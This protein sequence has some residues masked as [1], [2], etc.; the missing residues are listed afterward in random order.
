M[1]I[2]RQEIV[3]ELRGRR[4]DDLA[5]RAERELPELVDTDTDAHL[6]HALGINATDLIGGVGGTFG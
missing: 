2:E 3:D 5:D 4:E 1:E 6:L